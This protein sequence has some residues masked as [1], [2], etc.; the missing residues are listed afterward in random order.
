M[1]NATSADLSKFDRKVHGFILFDNCN[2]MQ[3]VLDQRA[4][5]EAN[6][7]FHR[8]GHSQTNIYSYQVYLGRVPIVVTIDENATWDDAEPWIQE[9]QYLLPLSGP[10]YV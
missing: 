1:Q 4:L 10:C 9:N 8:V 7:D 5:F 3:F 6:A 2:S